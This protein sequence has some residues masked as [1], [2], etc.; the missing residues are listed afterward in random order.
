MSDSS[1]VSRSTVYL[2]GAG[3]GDPGLITVRAAECLAQADV[4]IYDYLVN[5][6][7]LER[8]SSSAELIGLGHHSTGRDL[9]PD[10]IHELMIAK[11][12]EGNSVCRL[13]GGDASVFG[14][15]A[16]ET[17]AM[18]AAGVA[19][20][21]VPG[22]T[23]GLA[24]AAYAEIP[25][26]HH[27][28]ASAVALVAGQERH[29]KTKSAL[30]YGVLANFPGTLVFYMGVRKSE[31]WSRALIEHGKSPDTPVAIVG[32]CTRARQRMTRCTLETVWDVVQREGIRPPSLFVVGNVVGRAP[33]RSWFS[34]RP[35]FGTRVLVAGSPST[36]VKLRDSLSERGAE[37]FI[38]PAIRITDP[39]DWA[40]VDDA[41]DR[42]GQYDWLLFSS[43]SGV[44][45]LLRRIF[46]RGGDARTLGGVKLG[47]VGTGTADRLAKYHLKADLIPE[48]FRAESL[49]DALADEA[50]GKRFL[51]ARAS[52]GRKVLGDRIAAAG[53]DVDQIVVYGNIDVEEPDPKA[54]EMLA[55]G[56]IHWVTVTS[57]AV[58]RSVVQLYGDSLKNTRLASISPLTSSVLRELG[59]EPAA[60][61]SPHTMAALVEAIMQA[62]AVAE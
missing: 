56:D 47:V 32:W 62:K 30:D 1:S 35:L 42:I 11:A 45:Y 29:C 15:G 40:P 43:A 22:I 20:Q 28:D 36:S 9:S 27:D 57:S 21:I 3:P 49:A 60:E 48:Q 17:A 39:P 5:P 18:R 58:A 52:R 8:A 53:G 54:A 50:D 61:A 41:L 7:V 44:D 55:A 38:Q 6:A 33:D 23:A 2:V 51:L 12:Q 4:I 10:E 59:F 37:I 26:T 25:V 16:D 14:R 13:K 46:E 34:A 19:Y 24:V 31:Q